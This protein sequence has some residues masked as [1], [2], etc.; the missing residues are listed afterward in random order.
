LLSLRG[1]NVTACGPDSFTWDW[2]S[3]LTG[4][5]VGGTT[6]SYAYDGDDVR[7]RKTTGQTT[8]N[9]LWDRESGLPLL[10]DDGTTGYEHA[11]GV[12]EQ[13]SGTTGRTLLTDGLGSVR[14][15]ADGM[16]AL[17]GSADYEAFGGVRGMSTTGSVFGFTGEQTDPETGFLHLRARPYDP[18]TGRFLSAD[19]VQP[20][21]PGTQGYNLYAYVA[22]NPT[23]WMDPSGRNVNAGVLTSPAAAPVVAAAAAYFG[24]MFAGLAA[25]IPA[26]G[27]VAVGAAVAVVLLVVACVLIDECWGFVQTALT[28]GFET[29]DRAL[30]RLRPRPTHHA[31][32]TRPGDEA[33]EEPDATTGPTT[34]PTSVPQPATPD[35]ASP[36]PPGPDGRWNCGALK[37]WA[38][39]NFGTPVEDNPRRLVYQGR[40]TSGDTVRIIIRKVG[41]PGSGSTEARWGMQI[42]NQWVDPSTGLPP[43]P[44]Q[45][46]QHLPLDPAGC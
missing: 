2:R 3:R 8:V 19:T 17:I 42:N 36:P 15:S 46:V 1:R 30:D 33:G 4:A 35:F 26:G 20:N 12:Q 18:A 45:D 32:S 23:T 11:D 28:G 21:A 7:V 14:G 24:A 40:T 39:Q 5:T 13:I 31:P 9:Y 10:V 34:G 22:N 38:E 6:A 27:L 25:L 41:S 44:G 37:A 29:A 16:G 43:R